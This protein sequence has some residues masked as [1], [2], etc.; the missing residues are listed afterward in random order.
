VRLYNNLDLPIKVNMEDSTMEIKKQDNKQD[1]RQP[2]TELPVALLT[3]KD[4]SAVSGG[5]KSLW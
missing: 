1:K 2:K 3:E 4:M 5:T